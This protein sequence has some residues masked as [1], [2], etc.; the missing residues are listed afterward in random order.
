MGGSI[1]MKNQNITDGF[2]PSGYARLHFNS[3]GILVI[4]LPNGRS[5]VIQDERFGIPVPISDINKENGVAGIDDDGKIEYAAIS[6]LLLDSAKKDFVSGYAGIKE[7]GK[8][9]FD[10]LSSNVQTQGPKDFKNGYA[11]LNSNGKIYHSYFPDNVELTINRGRSNGSVSINNLTKI[12]EHQLPDTLLVSRDKDKLRRLINNIAY[13]VGSVYMNFIY[14]NNPYEILGV[15]RWKFIEE[16]NH[17]V[18]DNFDSYFENTLREVDTRSTDGMVT[19]TSKHIPHHRHLLFEDS[20]LVNDRTWRS[21]I[22]TASLNYASVGMPNNTYTFGMENYK[23]VAETWA[24]D[25]KTVRHILTSHQ[26]D[27]FDVA[28]SLQDKATPFLAKP[29]AIKT[30]IWYRLPDIADSTWESLKGYE[31][32]NPA[33]V[34]E[35]DLNFTTAIAELPRTD[36][37]DSVTITEIE[38]EEPPPFFTSGVTGTYTG[39]T[40]FELVNTLTGNTED[41]DDT[42]EDIISENIQ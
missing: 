32:E 7:D 25:G 3:N 27:N 23:G 31:M 22:S 41:S 28:D 34:N 15:G 8:L 10:S 6:H 9:R 13:P 14:N 16:G 5:S 18:A 4:T 19:L 1:E 29:K 21:H 2:T 38:T 12:H 24:P 30:F 36:V 33:K 42:I 35:E 17:I 37:T 26:T 39:G 11:G 20:K 40:N